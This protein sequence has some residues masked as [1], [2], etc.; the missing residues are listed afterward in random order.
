MRPCKDVVEWP[1]LAVY[2]I[3]TTD[4]TN[5]VLLCH[6]DEYGNRVSFTNVSDYVDWLFYQF[7]G[8]HVW[9]HAGGRFDH[10]FI[11][12]EVNRRGWDFRAALSGGTIVLMTIQAGGKKIFFADSFRLMPDALKK[13]GKTVG[14][15]KLDVNR[16]EIDSL[17]PEQALEY[18]FRDCDIALKGLQLMRDTFTSVN[19]D[20]AFTQFNWRQRISLGCFFGRGL[21]RNL[22]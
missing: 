8:Q 7:E 20:F 11:I 22:G 14:L 2:D 4:W 18:C 19:A 9:A 1:K 10:R 13:I 5:V 6:V 16:R 21:S 15:E 3:E 17:T 12:P